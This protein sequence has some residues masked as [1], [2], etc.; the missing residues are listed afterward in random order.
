MSMHQE[1]ADNRDWIPPLRHA[2]RDEEDFQKRKGLRA[3]S[4]GGPIQVGIGNV[5]S[6]E[7]QRQR[8]N[9][10]ILPKRKGYTRRRKRWRR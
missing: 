2:V 5:T 6:Q 7:R 3:I 9:L 1:Y 4:F 10:S 8:K